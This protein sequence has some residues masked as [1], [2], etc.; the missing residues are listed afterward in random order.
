RQ[1]YANTSMKDI[2]GEA[3]I[4]QGLIHYYFGSKDDLVIAVLREACSGLIAET[5]D[6]FESAEGSALMRIWPTLRIARERC[7]ERPE[8]WRLFFELLPL[9]FTNV[10]LRAQF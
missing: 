4:A 7:R 10:A 8:V 5:R 1:G 3:G 6:A 9:S 2:A